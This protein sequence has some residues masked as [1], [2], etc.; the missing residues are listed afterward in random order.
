[1][2]FRSEGDQVVELDGSPF[3]S[4]KAT[5]KKHALSALKTLVPCV[6]PVFYCAGFNY[7]AHIEWGNK[8]KGTNTKPPE[9]AD[10]GYR[11]NNALCANGENIVIPADSPG[12]VQF[13][14]ELVAVFG[15]RTRNVSPEQAL[16]CVMGWT[17]GNDVSERSWQKSDRT[18]FRSKNSDTF[19]PMGPWIVTGQIGRAHV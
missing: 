11:S 8:R 2:L 17:I 4:W 7:L 5:T 10:I 9:K 14:G 16:D 18:F 15:R 1:M 3:D 19:K 12:P 6:P 13:E